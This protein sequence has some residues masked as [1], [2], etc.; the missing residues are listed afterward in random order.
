MTNIKTADQLQQEETNFLKAAQNGNLD[1]MKKY[2]N[3]G[4]NKEAK[5]NNGWTALHFASN[6]GHLEIVQYLIET[7]SVNKEAK[8]NTGRTA[9]HCACAC[10]SIWVHLKIV[11]YLIET[12]RVNK[13]AKDND[14]WTALHYASRN[15]HL[16][17]VQYLIE[18]CHVQGSKRQSWIDCVALRQ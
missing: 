15:G 4:G 17:I 7:C 14:G 16:N 3:N 9:L 18:T 10:A 8:T 1:E 6:N 13:E 11:Q 2:I 5:D 12:C